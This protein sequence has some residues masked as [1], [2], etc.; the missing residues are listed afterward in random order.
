M[1]VMCAM[2]WVLLDLLP[3]TGRDVTT[4]ILEHC[5]KAHMHEGSYNSQIKSLKHKYVCTLGQTSSHQLLLG[6]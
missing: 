6:I 5:R 2:Q 1:V 4:F 3:F